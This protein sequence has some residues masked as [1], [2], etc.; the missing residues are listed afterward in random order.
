VG[1][2]E[3]GCGDD[4]SGDVGVF[5]GML[6]TIATTTQRNTVVYS[7]TGIQY[8][9]FPS[10]LML[11]LREQCSNMRQQFDRKLISSLQE[12]LRVL[13]SSNTGRGTGEDDGSGR[14]SRALR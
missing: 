8:N 2:P 4:I 3:V 14:Q 1:K 9:Q 7:N 5:T 13:R 6:C 11:H 12:L 10:L